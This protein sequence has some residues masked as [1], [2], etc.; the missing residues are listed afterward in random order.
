MVVP[1]K[2]LAAEGTAVLGAVGADE[3]L[4]ELACM[5]VINLT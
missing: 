2:K 3:A 5:M 4:Y 1:T